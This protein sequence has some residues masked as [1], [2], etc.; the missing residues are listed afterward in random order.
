MYQQFMSE[1]HYIAEGV[2]YADKRPVGLLRPS[3]LFGKCKNRLQVCGRKGIAT[4]KGKN[5][6][7]FWNAL[8]DAD[9]IMFGN[10]QSLIQL[11]GWFGD[12]RYSRTLSYLATLS[13]T[14]SDLS[15]KFDAIR[16]SRVLIIGCGGIGSLAAMNLAGATVGA[17]TLVDHDSIE[18]SNLNRQF[19]WSSDSVG[20]K[21][22]DVLRSTIIDRYPH[23][24]VTCIADKLGP[25][26]VRQ[27]S[28]DHDAIVITADEPLGFA[29]SIIATSTKFVTYGGYFQ[30][31]WGFHA[32]KNLQ[33]NQST[34]GTTSWSRN[35]YFIG[36]SFG[37]GNTE[38]AGAMA[39]VCIHYLIQRD[40]IE[41]IDVTQVW[42]G[43]RISSSG[44]L[45]SA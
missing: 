10:E 26:Q 17:I 43:D 3:T 39:S 44:Q 20:L 40:K 21:K 18:E 23:V 8:I 25:R 15:E 22:V 33:R 30:G 19:F 36:P 6:S 13:T 16:A 35:P 14:C 34:D 9:C 12:P 29:A 28:L 42:L 5:V 4:I 2:V 1:S 7:G 31:Y 37:P 38:I 24:S 41:H 32:S 45:H 11:R 27:L